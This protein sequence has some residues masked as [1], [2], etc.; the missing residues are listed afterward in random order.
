M[1]IYTSHKATEKK[2]S[3]RRFDQHMNNETREQKAKKEREKKNFKAKYHY[4]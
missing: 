3:R 1:P 4:L 2:N